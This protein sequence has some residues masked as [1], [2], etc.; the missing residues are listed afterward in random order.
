[1]WPTAASNPKYPKISAI[2]ISEN[3]TGNPRNMDSS[4]PGNINRTKYSE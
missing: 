1:M 2:P 4:T 3:A